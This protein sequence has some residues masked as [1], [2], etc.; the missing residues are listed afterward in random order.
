MIFHSDKKAI[1]YPHLYIDNSEIE[2][3]KQISW[4]NI[5]ENIK[6]CR[7]PKKVCISRIFFL[8]SIMH[9]LYPTIIVDFV[10]AQILI[11]RDCFSIAGNCVD[12]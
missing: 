2:N 6:S 3:V 9:S 5:N 12:N 10:G 7:H 4:T 8:C 11:N 1:T